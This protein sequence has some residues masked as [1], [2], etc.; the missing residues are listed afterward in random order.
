M[1]A[2]QYMTLEE[3][4][5]TGWKFYQEAMKGRM[6]PTHPHFVPIGFFRVES[7]GGKSWPLAIWE[8]DGKKLAQVGDATPVDLSTPEAEEDFAYKT[9]Q[10]CC[11]RP[12][13]YTAYEHWKAHRAWPPTD[14]A[15]AVIEA[16]QKARAD[17]A[18]NR[19]PGIG[20]NSG[21][22][23]EIDFETFVDQAEAALAGVKAASTVESEEQAIAANSLRNRLSEIASEGDKRRETEKKPHL[24]AGKAI[25][26]RWNPKIKELRAA[27]TSLRTAAESYKTRQIREQ[28]EREA[29]ARAASNPVTEAAPPDRIES[30]YGKR[31]TVKTILVAKVVDQDAVYRQLRGNPEIVQLIDKLAQKV[32]TAGGTLEGVETEERASIR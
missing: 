2:P 14:G 24:E 5:A 25:D 15:T 31:S 13:S 1:S 30:T 19:E 6:L 20:D 21:A 27:A 22:N 11:K 3:S 23:P 4:R 18:Q 10:Y 9:F 7:K 8:A 26:G 32:I 16:S 12:I 29:A 28:R 17:A